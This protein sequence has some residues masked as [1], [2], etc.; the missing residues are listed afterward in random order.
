M[1]ES[2]LK[3]PLITQYR[4][5]NLCEA[6]CGLKIELKGHK[7]LSIKGDQQD[8][9]SQAHICPKAVALQD[10]YQDKD[11]LTKP[12][13]KTA[14]GWQEISWKEAFK[15]VG[16]QIKNIQQQYGRN[17]VGAILVLVIPGCITA[18]VW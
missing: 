5:C 13:K 15:Q 3:S 4:T 8:P 11:R 16:S 7:I 1:P 17:A 12:V 2:Q 14:N 9:F 6:M 18:I 10:L